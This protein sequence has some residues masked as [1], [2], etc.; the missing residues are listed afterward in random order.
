MAFVPSMNC[1]IIGVSVG[2]GLMTLRRMPR[3]AKPFAA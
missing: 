2:P 1:G 3:S